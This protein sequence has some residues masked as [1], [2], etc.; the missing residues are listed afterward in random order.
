ML[1][2]VNVLHFCFIFFPLVCALAILLF[3]K[4]EVE[5]NYIALF[6]LISVGGILLLSAES[7]FLFPL[8]PVMLF[9]IGA[10]LARKVNLK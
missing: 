3:K 4:M 2:I 9:L 5:L 10:V 7:R 6:F 8:Y 1:L